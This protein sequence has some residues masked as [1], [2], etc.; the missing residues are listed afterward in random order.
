ML[1]GTEGK[2][3]DSSNDE[4]TIERGGN[5][6]MCVLQ[7]SEFL[8][9]WNSVSKFLLEIQVREEIFSLTERREGSAVTIAPPRTSL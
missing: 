8:R 3:L 9:D 5:S 2:G 1:T 4:P 7:E 6:S